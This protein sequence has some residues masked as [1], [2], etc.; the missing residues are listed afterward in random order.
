[1]KT[2][3]ILLYRTVLALTY[4]AFLFSYVEISASPQSTIVAPLN[5]VEM[6]KQGET[7]TIPID[8][9][10]GK[11]Q[12]TA[13]SQKK[14][15]DIKNLKENT[16]FDL[17]KNV[18]HQNFWRATF[19]QWVVA[20]TAIIGAGLSGWAVFLLYRT[21]AETTK[22]ASVASEANQTA[23]RAIEAN[24]S[25]GEAQVR[26]H[27]AIL[28]VKFRL[29]ANKPEFQINLINCGQTPARNVEI[30]FAGSYRTGLNS[31]MPSLLISQ[32]TNHKWLNDVGPNVKNKICGS[33]GLN[34]M[35]GPTILLIKDT[36]TQITLNIEIRYTDIFGKNLSV[37]YFLMALSGPGHSISN[38]I[39]FHPQPGGMGSVIANN[40]SE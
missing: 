13:I 29:K 28:E 6:T 32:N 9:K 40:D 24:R 12:K 17:I 11:P 5:D 2:T 30:R 26:A 4:F 19:T 8:P 20:I 23:E 36:A 16:K 35:D 22:T 33:G 18:G 27:F 10:D 21:L 34:D 14:L 25:I 31:P 7:I 38:W 37:Q 3:K 1:M 15:P 39:L